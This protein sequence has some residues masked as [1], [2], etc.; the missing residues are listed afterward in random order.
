M[1]ENGLVNR[2]REAC[3]VC[4]PKPC[5]RATPGARKSNALALGG[6][7]ERSKG[8]CKGR[9]EAICGL[10][11]DN[12]IPELRHK[13]AQHGHC[14][15]ANLSEIRRGRQPSPIPFVAIRCPRAQKFVMHGF[16][17]WAALIWASRSWRV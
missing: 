11:G 3:S 14:K 5:A 9:R 1:R 12:L 17:I 7:A 15:V 16:E 8:G 2:A 10:D 4:S 6:Q 13:C